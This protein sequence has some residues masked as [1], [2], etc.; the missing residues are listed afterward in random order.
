MSHTES[1]ESAESFSGDSVDSVFTGR[2]GDE[3]DNDRFGVDSWGRRATAVGA[4]AVAEMRIGPVRLARPM[5][6]VWEGVPQLDFATWP[7][8]VDGLFGNAPFFDRTIVVDLPHRRFGI[9]D[10]RD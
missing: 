2:S 1:T 7:F 6:Y 8:R 9:V 4:P 3:A 5:V 10:P